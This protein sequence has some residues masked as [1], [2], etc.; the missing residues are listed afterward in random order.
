MIYFE[1][2]CR[3]RTITLHMKVNAT[4]MLSKQI[5]IR[6]LWLRHFITTL[7]TCIIVQA[8]QQVFALFNVGGSTLAIY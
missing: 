7:I 5:I 8:S 2:V 6:H 1:K 4:S 3:K